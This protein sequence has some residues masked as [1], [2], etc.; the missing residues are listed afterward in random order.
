MA[1]VNN[2]EDTMMR[3][4]NKISEMDKSFDIE[5]WQ[6]QTSSER[7]AAVWEMVEM[8]HLRKGGSK[9]ELR[10]QRTVEHFQRKSG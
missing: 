6:R 9:D 10:L 8:Y 2:T 3:F 7:L 4:G 1:V 5:Y